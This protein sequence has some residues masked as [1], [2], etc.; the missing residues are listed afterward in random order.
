VVERTF[1]D[2]RTAPVDRRVPTEWLINSSIT[3][4]SRA[5]LGRRSHH[6]IT[7]GFA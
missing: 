4:E 5:A 7:P 3:I 2:R 6:R 1:A